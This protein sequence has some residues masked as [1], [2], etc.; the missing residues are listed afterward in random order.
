MHQMLTAEKQDHVRS[1]AEACNEPTTGMRWAQLT[2]NWTESTWFHRGEA[3]LKRQLE[4]LDN[5]EW[6]LIT[7]R[8]AQQISEIEDFRFSPIYFAPPSSE[9]GM[10]YIPFFLK[11]VITLPE[12]GHVGVLCHATGNH[13]DIIICRTTKA[14]KLVKIE[15]QGSRQH[16][17][18]KLE[19]PFTGHLVHADALKLTESVDLKQYKDRVHALLVKQGTLMPWQRL[20]ILRLGSMTPIRGNT[21][22]WNPAWKARPD[23]K[24]VKKRLFQKTS[25]VQ[26]CITHFCE[27]AR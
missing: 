14:D 21:L 8:K 24:T 20:V 27:L 3:L 9:T 22:L 7:D 12:Y 13:P 1:M 6:K 23:A 11:Q 17:S 5:D 18:V 25:L 10:G 19:N 4:K 16:L 26:L 15:V 2:W